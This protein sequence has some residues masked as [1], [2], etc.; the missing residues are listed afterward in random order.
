MKE[1]LL[2]VSKVSS[3]RKYRSY[4]VSV[5]SHWQK[6][7]ICRCRLASGGSASWSGV[8]V[9]SA[10]RSWSCPAA[11]EISCPPLSVSRWCRL[12]QGHIH[13]SREEQTP[14]TNIQT[15]TT[16]LNSRGKI[17]SKMWTSS[18]SVCSCTSKLQCAI[19][20]WEPP[21]SILFY[22]L[23]NWRIERSIRTRVCSFHFG[24]CW[25]VWREKW[26]KHKLAVVSLF[27]TTWRANAGCTWSIS[28]Y[29]TFTWCRNVGGLTGKKWEEVNLW[30]KWSC[31]Q[32]M[33]GGIGEV[34]MRY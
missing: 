26:E 4:N 30:R 27:A 10:G 34:C 3:R 14:S 7:R 6:S 22:R 23:F 12:E 2:Y 13:T 31:V 28:Q 20:S 24:M 25:A 17:W 19:Q 21:P 5:D 1:R 8:D 16:P 29:E 15:E 33:F 18:I 32:I 9:S 11:L